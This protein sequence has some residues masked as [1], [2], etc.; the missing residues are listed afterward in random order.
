M[1]P[2]SCW[3]FSS[4]QKISRRREIFCRLENIQQERGSIGIPF[5]QNL[6]TVSNK[7]VKG[8]EPHP[9]LYMLFNEAYL[10]A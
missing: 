8:F 7:R 10:E 1:E 4:L 3:M 6:W 5:W 9:N 2:L